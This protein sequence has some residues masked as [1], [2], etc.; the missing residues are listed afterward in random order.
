MSKLPRWTPEQEKILLNGIGVY[1]LDWLRRHVGDRSTCALQAKIRRQFGIGGGYCRGTYTLLQA[2]DLT[3]YER[4]MLRRAGKA[5]GQR[6]ARTGRGGNFLITDDQMAEVVEWL[7]DDYWSKKLRLYCCVECGTDRKPHH[8]LG[9][10]GRCYHRT[11]RVCT[12]FGA[13]LVITDLTALVD[14]AKEEA[15]QGVLHFLSRLYRDLEAGKSPVEEDLVHFFELGIV[16][17]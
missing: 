9:L 5:L 3:G 13:R 14:Q 7:R 15:P 6:W 10:C 2:A 8:R 1:G 12:R 11:R 16:A 4:P 17:A